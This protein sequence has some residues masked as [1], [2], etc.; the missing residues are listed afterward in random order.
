L[1]LEAP[2]YE[3]GCYPFECAFCR[4]WKP[5][6]F[7]DTPTNLKEHDDQI[8]KHPTMGY[9]KYTARNELTAPD[10]LRAL[11]LL[12][13]VDLGGKFIFLFFPIIDVQ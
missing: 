6:Q 4:A 13:V 7:S 11:P 12:N 5:L 3:A 2:T 9:K 10:S 8:W 1:N